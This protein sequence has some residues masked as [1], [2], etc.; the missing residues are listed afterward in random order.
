MNILLVEDQQRLADA[1]SA[2]LAND[3]YHV[4]TV[5]DGQSGLDYALS[6]GDTGC[7]YDAIVLDVMLPRMDGITVARELRKAGRSVPIIM[8][9]A[10]NTLRDKV[11][12][13]DS[14]ADDYLTKPFQPEELLARLRAMTRRS[15]PVIVDNIVLGNLTLDLKSG[16]LFNHESDK[17]Q[18]VHLSQREFDLCQMLMANP[19]QVM[20]KANLLTRIWGMDNDADENSVEAYIS[21]LRKK[22][23][24]LSANLAITTIRGMGYRLEV[25][26][27]DESAATNSEEKPQMIEA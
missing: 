12:G 13:L 17:D 6:A 10:R 8:L 20:T 11:T 22:L 2:I 15:G 23:N 19:T 3:G 27:K 25:A 5:Y 1:L 7:D 9:T 18:R 16:F 24:Y 4:D 26:Q 14:G 21:F